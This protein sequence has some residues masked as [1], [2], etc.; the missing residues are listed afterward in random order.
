MKWVRVCPCVL[1]MIRNHEDR[2][3]TD[4]L[5]LQRAENR[6]E[7]F[8]SSLQAWGGRFWCS[9]QGTA[10]LNS[11]LGIEQLI[12]KFDQLQEFF[13]SAATPPISDRFRIV[14]NSIVPLMVQQFTH[15]SF[16]GFEQYSN[17]V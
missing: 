5:H 15:Q 16:V 1:D 10:T 13:L 2:R 4:S 12:Y 14:I 17:H 9:L 6:H 3:E 8:S 7:E 11:K